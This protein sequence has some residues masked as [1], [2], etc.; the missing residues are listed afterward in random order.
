MADNTTTSLTNQYQRH[1][2]K[3][4]LDHVKFNLRFNQF[5]ASRNLPRGLGAKT[6]RYYRRG[7]ASSA[8]VLTLT[9]GVVPT[10]FR[11]VDYTPVDVDLVQFGEGERFTDLVGWTA[12]LDVLED[13]ID[14][15]GEDCALKADDL[16]Q[17]AITHPTTG[18]TKRYSGGA[19]TYNALVALT[20]AAG[21]Y[22]SEDGL[23]AVTQLAI[24]KA[25]RKNGQYIGIVPPQISFNLKRDPAWLNAKTY[26]DVQ[27]LFKGEAGELDGIRY[28]EHNNGWGE[29]NTNGTEGTRETTTPVIWSSVFTGK[30]SYGVVALSGQGYNSPKVMICDKPDKS[31]FLNQLLIA[32]W[33][34]Y[35]AS[36]VLNPAFGVVV[37][38]KTTFVAA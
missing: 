13:G 27:G 23:A 7:V 16:T 35:Y 10:T 4:L 29:A 28:V 3:E 33:K 20:V 1:F 25:P 24:N 22:V 36:A 9:E 6:V 19:T 30:D 38:S 17:A 37:R 8:N 34:A 11:S 26:S 5:G 14:L 31:D 18:L 21:K 32:G 15:M 12:L 2:S